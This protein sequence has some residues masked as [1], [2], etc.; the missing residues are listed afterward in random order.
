MKERKI[1]QGSYIDPNAQQTLVEEA[2]KKGI[3]TTRLVSEILE[4]AAKRIT[5]RETRDEN[6]KGDNTKDEV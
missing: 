5:A 4:K 3:K 6:N 1:V 2:K